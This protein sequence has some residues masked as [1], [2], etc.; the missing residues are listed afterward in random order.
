MHQNIRYQTH[1][2]D[3]LL[4]HYQALLKRHNLK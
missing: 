1:F 3:S 4:D 2:I